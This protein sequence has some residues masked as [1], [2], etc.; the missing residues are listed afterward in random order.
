MSRTCPRC[1]CRLSAYTPPAQQLCGPCTTAT[2]DDPGTCKRGHDRRT[3]GY[4]HHVRWD[5]RA[6]ERLRRKKERAQ[7]KAARLEEGT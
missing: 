5:C 4:R 7:R 3:D 1:G 2:K 6:C